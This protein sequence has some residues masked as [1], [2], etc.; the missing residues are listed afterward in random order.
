M[1]KKVKIKKRSRDNFSSSVKRQL[2]KRAMSVCS[3]PGCRLLTRFIP[4]GRKKQK[5]VNIGEGAHI[6]AAASGGPRFDATKK[7]R[8]RDSSLRL[9][10]PC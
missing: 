1:N 2:E 5:A 6:T 4:Y 8:E 10:F 3:F 9:G 7:S